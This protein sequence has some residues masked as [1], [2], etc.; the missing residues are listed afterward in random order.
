L[1]E[2]CLPRYSRN[3]LVGKIDLLASTSSFADR[4]RGELKS[5]TQ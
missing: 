5:S 1:E 4:S 2:D 3:I